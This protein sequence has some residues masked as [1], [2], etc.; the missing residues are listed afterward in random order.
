MRRCGVLVP[1]MLTR[2]LSTLLG[3][4][5]VSSITSPV[6]ARAEATSAPLASPAACS[7]SA[8]TIAPR[9]DAACGRPDGPGQAT[10]DLLAHVAAGETPPAGIAG[11]SRRAANAARGRADEPSGGSRSRSRSSARDAGPRPHGAAAAFS[12]PQSSRAGRRGRVHRSEEEQRENSGCG[13]PRGPERLLEHGGGARQYL[14]V[15]RQA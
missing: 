14:A 2:A 12:G 1:A 5:L 8:A 6:N 9:S 3:L 13:K 4:A 11:A 15:V 7:A 10:W